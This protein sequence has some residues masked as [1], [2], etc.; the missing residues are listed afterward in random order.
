M[1]LAVQDLLGDYRPAH[2]EEILAAANAI[3]AHRFRRGA[4][5]TD[6]SPAKSLFRQKLALRAQ[7]VFAVVFLDNRHRQ[8]AYEELFFGTI[9]STTVHP[10]VIAQR[11]LTLNAAAVILGHNHP[12]GLPNPSQAD[13]NITHRLKETLALLD[14]RVLDHIIVGE[15]AYSMAEHGF[16]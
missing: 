12:S 11:V 2:P 1:K 5:F 8:I 10:R 14:V 13:H 15:E 16:I 3:I 7:E 4:L 6:P 9:D